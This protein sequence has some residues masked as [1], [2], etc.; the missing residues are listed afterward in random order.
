MQARQLRRFAAPQAHQGL[1][2]TITQRQRL[3]CGQRRHLCQPC[4]ATAEDTDK[5][6]KTVN[7]LDALLGIDPEEEAKAEAKAAARAATAASGTSESAS[8]PS[9]RTGTTST[10][11]TTPGTKQ[12]QEFEDQFQKI[13]EKARQLGSAQADKPGNLEGQQQQLRQEFESLLQ[14]MSKDQGMLS[15]DDIKRLKEA[16][17]GPMSYWVTEVATLAEADRVGVLVRGNLREDRNKVFDLVCTKVKE[18]FDGK[19]EVLL[20]EDADPSEEPSPQQAARGPKVAFQIVPVSQVTPPTAGTFRQVSAAILFSLW[21]LSS[22]QLALVAN[23]T[24]LPKETLEY[25][26]NPENFNG[27][28]DVIPPG[29]CMHA[30]RFP[31]HEAW[32]ACLCVPS[33]CYHISS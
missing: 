18:L 32:L 5:V 16:C 2:V 15:K 9:L 8:P 3:P 33:A 10:S 7:A 27:T 4:H 11:G 12:E 31:W 6:K 20:V 26:A 19:Y 29:E 14:A 25:F 21:L 22:L 17:F 1:Q 28:T 23:I 30:N 13:I 24:K